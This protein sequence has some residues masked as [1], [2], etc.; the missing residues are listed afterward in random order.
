MGYVLVWVGRCS[1]SLHHPA[2]E[3]SGRIRCLVPAITNQFSKSRGRSEMSLP[4]L[5]TFQL[6]MLTPM[7]W[8]TTRTYRYYSQPEEVHKVVSSF[9][10]G[11]IH[12]MQADGNQ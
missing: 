6:Q 5:R 12:F 10:R 11:I 1:H 3:E 7:T 9:V 2:K 4:L 8:F